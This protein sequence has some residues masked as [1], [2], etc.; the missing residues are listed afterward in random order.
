[1]ELNKYHKEEQKV[2][3]NWHNYL[4]EIE[5]R[6]TQMW[7][8]IL[9]NQFVNEEIRRLNRE[10]YFLRKDVDDEK[11]CSKQNHTCHVRNRHRCA[12]CRF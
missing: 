2:M 7:N 1:M 12:G 11:G 9:Y 4:S 3:S 5:Q 8:T 6:N 10:L